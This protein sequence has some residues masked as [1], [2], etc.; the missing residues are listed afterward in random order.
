[1]AIVRRQGR[2][3]DSKPCVLRG[4]VALVLGAT[5]FFTVGVSALQKVSQHDGLLTKASMALV[6][7][8]MDA[9]SGHGGH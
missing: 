6:G 9:L 7:V 8:P 3:V 5:L 2:R 1:M 4:V